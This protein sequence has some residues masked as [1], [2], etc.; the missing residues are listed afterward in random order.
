MAQYKE[1]K[2]EHNKNLALGVPSVAPVKPERPKMPIEAKVIRPAN[3][4]KRWFRAVG[5]ARKITLNRAGLARQ[6]KGIAQGKT[7][8]SQM[9]EEHRGTKGSLVSIDYLDSEELRKK[10]QEILDRMDGNRPF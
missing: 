8:E 6:A 2:K 5:R 9:V 10:R 1:D 7:T 4:V 3:E